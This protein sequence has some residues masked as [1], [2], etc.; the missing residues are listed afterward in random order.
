[1]ARDGTIQDTVAAVSCFLNVFYQLRRSDNN[2]GFQFS[3]GE[4]HILSVA[5]DPDS[6]TLHLDFS[7]GEELP[8]EFGI[9]FLLDRQIH[10]KQPSPQHSK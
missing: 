4:G 7:T 5:V 10:T 6:D 1:M 2:W 9:I 3:Y 8:R